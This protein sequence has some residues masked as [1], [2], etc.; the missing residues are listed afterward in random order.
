MHYKLL[1]VEYKLME[2]RG[3]GLLQLWC[4]GCGVALGCRVPACCYSLTLLLSACSYALTL[5]LVLRS[6]T[7]Y[8]TT[9]EALNRYYE[10]EK[11]GMGG[12][13]EADMKA[14]IEAHR[15]RR[16]HLD[17]PIYDA[18]MQPHLNAPIHAHIP[19]EQD[20]CYGSEDGSWIGASENRCI[21]APAPPPPPPCAGQT[22]SQS[23]QQLE[24]GSNASSH[25]LH[26]FQVIVITC[27][28]SMRH[29]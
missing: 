4:C 29:V 14:G 8:T 18:A 24:S 23:S 15:D 16:M 22:L 5:A 13:G 20:A 1:K 21:E 17:A 2:F 26:F 11:L 10:L 6:Y 27:I 3:V 9:R 12:G 25:P 19:A 28:F 7:T